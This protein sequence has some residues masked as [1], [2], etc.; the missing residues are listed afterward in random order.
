MAR[1]RYGEARVAQRYVAQGYEVLARNWRAGRSGEL[2][3]IVGR[4]DQVVVCEVKARASTRYGTPAAAV[5]WRKQRRI[6]QLTAAWLRTAEH[7]PCR[8]RFD[9]AEVVGAQVRVI[10]GAF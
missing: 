10:E 2:D 1:G 3:L 6:R 4:G 8:I 5:D 9:V 7:G